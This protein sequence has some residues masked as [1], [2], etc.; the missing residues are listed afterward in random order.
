MKIF[1]IDFLDQNFNFYFKHESNQNQEKINRI[2]NV[3]YIY[4]KC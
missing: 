1:E 2:G 3:K 4:T